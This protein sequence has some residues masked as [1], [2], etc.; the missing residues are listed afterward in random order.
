MLREPDLDLQKAIKLGQAAEETKQHIK[1]LSSEMNS[2]A[3][4][5][6]VTKNSKAVKSQMSNFRAGYNNY[7][8]INNCTFCGKSHKQ[9]E[10]P[11]YGRKCHKCK[12]DNHFAK[13]CPSR[14]VHHI[15]HN[16][17]LSNAGDDDSEF[18]IGVINSS[19][20]ENDVKSSDW[21]VN[22]C[23]NQRIIKF[24][25]VTGAQCNV[26]P[27]SIFSLLRPR[28]KMHSSTIKFEWLQLYISHRRT[29]SNFSAKSSGSRQ[30]LNLGIAQSQSLI[31]LRS[32]GTASSTSENNSGSTNDFDGTYGEPDSD[33]D[34]ESQSPPQKIN[35]SKELDGAVD[36]EEK[37]L[38]HRAKAD[39][40][41]Q[42]RTLGIF[43][44]SAKSKNRPWTKFEKPPSKTNMDKLLMTTAKS[45]TAHLREAREQAALKD[46]EDDEESLFCR[47]LIPRLKRLPNRT[48]AT[49]R[50]QIEQLFFQSEYC[51]L[52]HA[53]QPP[54]FEQFN[55]NT[56]SVSDTSNYPPSIN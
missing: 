1:E 23:I 29:V 37:I 18:Y 32:P 42:S 10:C 30:M 21:S 44:G 45:I 15:V 51:S 28:P 25:I 12:K 19:N 34:F 48:R 52:Y 33:P 50:L 8:M 27:E 5:N 20:V 39:K 55:L 46:K 31:S 54:Q 4:V 3:S 13:F 16:D 14:R 11:A 47:S 2:Q 49:I 26:L 38:E 9:G 22:L 41:S 40:L 43:S 24:K 7:A 35:E 17:T 36:E 6:Y 56:N 53:P